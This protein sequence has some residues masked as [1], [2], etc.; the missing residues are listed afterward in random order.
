MTTSP[1][2]EKGFVLVYS[3]LVLMTLI[4]LAAL[5]TAHMSTFALRRT[6]LSLQ[7]A[8]ARM[9]TTRCMELLLLDVRIDPKQTGSGRL[10]QDAGEC[11]YA[12]SGQGPTKDLRVVATARKQTQAVRV[13]V[14][15]VRPVIQAQWFDTRP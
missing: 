13:E 3:L 12:I 15:A 5:S 9:L 14:Y 1:K 6:A 11:V 2:D 4:T 7:G 10:T 8:E